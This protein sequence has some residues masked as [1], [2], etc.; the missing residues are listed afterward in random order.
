MDDPLHTW[1][2]LNAQQRHNQQ[3][4]SR[5]EAALRRSQAVLDGAHCVL[6]AM[7]QSLHETEETAATPTSKNTEPPQ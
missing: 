6:V 1:Y 5:V 2:R 7:Q 3:R 4:L